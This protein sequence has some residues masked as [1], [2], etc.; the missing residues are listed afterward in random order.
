MQ[1]YHLVIVVFLFSLLCGC[2]LQPFFGWVATTFTTGHNRPT[3]II[4]ENRLIELDIH[5]I[6]AIYLPMF[7]NRE[8]KNGF[9]EFVS[10]VPSKPDKLIILVRKYGINPDNME[11]IRMIYQRSEDKKELYFRSVFTAEAHRN[12]CNIFFM[13]QKPENVR[14][15]FYED[16]TKTHFFTKENAKK[17]SEKRHLIANHSWVSENKRESEILKSFGKKGTPPEIYYGFLFEEVL[18]DWFICGELPTNMIS[19]PGM[20]SSKVFPNEIDPRHFYQRGYPAEGNDILDDP[21]G[22]RRRELFYQSV[23]EH[24]MRILTREVDRH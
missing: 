8:W 5:G 12:N 7:H 23:N 11:F 4:T 13:I 16:L 19:L 3:E 6:E 9:H 17:E 18:G 22:A 20:Q 2:S 15:E 24:N 14:I 10:A 21:E 1:K